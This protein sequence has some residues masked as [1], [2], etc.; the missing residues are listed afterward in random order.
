MSSSAAYDPRL[1]VS[2]ED[3]CD[4]LKKIKTVQ[5]E[6]LDTMVEKEK[7]LVEVD[8]DQLE[9][10]REVE[11]KLIRRVIEEERERLLVTEEVGDLLEFEHPSQITVNEMLEDLPE[12]LGEQLD[13]SRNNL[14]QISTNLARQNALNRSLV[15]HTVG[16]VQVFLSKLLSEELGT[17]PYN[18]KGKT[19]KDGSG[20]FLMD[21][22]G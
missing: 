10:V 5:E 1:R 19:G 22:K 11:E 21:R 6:L 17:A 13:E 15:E 8:L 20:P 7:A 4:I 18:E 3:L 9:A 12:A 2:V 14:R 16:H